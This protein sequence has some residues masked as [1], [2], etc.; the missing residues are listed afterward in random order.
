MASHA[1]EIS[2]GAEGHDK[3]HQILFQLEEAVVQHAAIS[4]AQAISLRPSRD[5]GCHDRHVSGHRV[6]DPDPQD[7]DDH[8]QDDDIAYMGSRAYGTCI[9][10]V[11]FLERFRPYGVDKYTDEARPNIWLA[12]CTTPHASLSGG[13][14]LHG[15]EIPSSSSG[16]DKNGQ[17]RRSQTVANAAY[18][19]HASRKISRPRPIGGANSTSPN[20]KH[21]HRRQSWMNQKLQSEEIKGEFPQEDTP[22]TEDFMQ[23]TKDKKQ[24]INQLQNLLGRLGPVSYR[25]F[26]MLDDYMAN[27]LDQ[28]VR[29]GPVV[30]MPTCT[31]D[32]EASGGESVR[33][34]PPDIGVF[35]PSRCI[36]DAGTG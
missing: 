29:L 8:P 18:G 2:K 16:R 7:Q 27:G 13:N 9:R 17:N 28:L 12:N 31:L 30:R 3:I 14:D 34:V 20:D 35:T 1:I 15:C 25:N 5:N 21:H 4:G 22:K 33:N 10:N 24:R 6:E 11:K 32:L 26:M 36:K 19:S 23:R